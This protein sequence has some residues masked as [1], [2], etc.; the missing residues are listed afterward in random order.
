M[1]I[2]NGI[3][4]IIPI[5]KLKLLARIVAKNNTINI[6]IKTGKYLTLRILEVFIS[7]P[8]GI[9]TPDLLFDRQTL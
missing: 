6:I 8:K 5:N 3:K 9:R 7:P 4:T 2:I 1:Q